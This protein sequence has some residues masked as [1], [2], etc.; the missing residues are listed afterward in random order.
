MVSSAMGIL[1][2]RMRRS[3]EPQASAYNGADQKAKSTTKGT[4]VGRDKGADRTDVVGS[5]VE[6][7][8]TRVMHPPLMN[9]RRILLFS[10]HI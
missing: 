1:S 10:F 5:I 4:M 8:L 9:T 7:R 6:V 3:K 2:P